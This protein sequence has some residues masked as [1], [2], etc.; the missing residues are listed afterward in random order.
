MRLL[1]ILIVLIIGNQAAAQERRWQ[2]IGKDD[3]ELIR[4]NKKIHC[5]IG[6]RAYEIDINN[7]IISNG[8]DPLANKKFWRCTSMEGMAQGVT[9]YYDKHCRLIDFINLFKYKAEIVNREGFTPEEMP[10][11]LKRRENVAKQKAWEKS[12]ENTKSTNQITIS[13]TSKEDDCKSWINS[14]IADPTPDKKKYIKE[15]C[16]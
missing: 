2:C 15:N 1:F 11:E 13:N 16:S 10:I 9:A 4:A 7:K 6:Y 5:P 3:K 12:L 14:N 8:Y